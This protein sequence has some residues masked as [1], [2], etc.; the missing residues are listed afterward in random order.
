MP[1]EFVL[2]RLNHFSLTEPRVILS[3]LKPMK[4]LLPRLVGFRLI[5]RRWMCSLFL[6]AAC[7]LMAASVLADTKLVSNGSAVRI[8]VPHDGSLGDTWRSP[9]FNDAS[10]IRG[11]NGVGYETTP[12][13][14]NAR[15]IA[16]SQAD[17]SFAGRQGE[18][19]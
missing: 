6:T 12:G 3:C 18:N 16:D 10:W 9:S 17:W 2:H 7:A 15:V 19:S 4:T 1:H 14:F 13:A 8:F 5:A 11:T